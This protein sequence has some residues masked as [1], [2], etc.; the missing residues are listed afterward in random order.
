MNAFLS[1]I[2][3]LDSVRDVILLSLQGEL[4]FCRQAGVSVA[5]DREVALWN[6]IIGNLSRPASA[7]LVFSKGRYYLYATDIGY[8]IIGMANDKSLKKIRV[9]CV[10]V[11]EKLVDPAVCKKVLLR[12]LSDGAEINKPHIINALVPLADEEV[13]NVLLPVLQQRDTFHP[14]I[15]EKL[16]LSLCWALGGSA[17]YDA[18]AP[19]KK[20]L[21]AYTSTTSPA[22]RE[23][24]AAARLAIQQ[25]E[26]IQSGKAKAPVGETSLKAPPSAKENPTQSGHIENSSE[27]SGLEE[28]QIQELLGRG[29]K[30]EAITLV[31][32]LITGNAKAKRF[33]KAEHLRDWLM[34]IDS[35]ALTESIRA[36]EIIEEEKRASISTEYFE[37]WKELLNTLSA[38]ESS[39]L[40][41]AMTPRN[42]SEGEMVV[43]RGEFL[44]ALFFINSGHVQMYADSQGREVSLKNYGQGEIM[45]GD[46]FFDASVW[47]V[48][49]VSKGAFISLLTLQRLKSQKDNCP[50]LYGKLQDF[51]MRYI[52]PGDLFRK[53][54]RTRRNF[55]RKKVSGRVT[56]DLLDQHGNETGLGGKGELLDISKG[57][58]ALSLRF[59]K[60]KSAAALLGQKIRVNIRPDAS[61]EPIMCV[62]QVMTVRC[63]DFIGNDY[64]LHIQFE[65]ELSNAEI[66]RI[67]G[68]GR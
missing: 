10:N 22:G 14:D 41:H 9:A 43:K 46:T 40:Y 52:S 4:L 13:A 65:S 45:G 66:Q 60:K 27:E 64:S 35:M 8:L 44:P 54:N 32:Q 67:A 57:G 23:I 26:S 25:L 21:K 53:T 42:Y 55:E 47:T 12:M 68:K 62:G 11:Q 1:K 2:S 6:A 15:K 20:V 58:V 19:L 51:C 18:V 50:A 39:S 48:N 29:Q 30:R 3:Q 61:L 33:E 17:T 7:D 49:A 31:M 37:T 63:H 24:E 5:I 59:S 16:L 36:A 38:E 28:Q 56:I 34:Q